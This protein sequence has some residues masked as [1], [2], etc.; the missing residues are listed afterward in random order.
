MNRFQRQGF[1]ARGLTIIYIVGLALCIGA[2][3]RGHGQPAFLWVIGLYM[4]W[5]LVWSA[6]RW[7]SAS[8]RQADF[9]DS[10]K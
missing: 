9:R 10:F 7:R 2:L 4:F 3:I 5:R 8:R 6:I 1:A